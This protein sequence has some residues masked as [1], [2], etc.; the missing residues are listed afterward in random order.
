[1]E[2]IKKIKMSN[3]RRLL[4]DYHD[5]EPIKNKAENKAAI[6]VL[7]KF[8]KDTNGKKLNA[9]E[10]SFLDTLSDRIQDYEKKYS[11]LLESDSDGIESLK[12]LMDENGI[13]NTD[14]AMILRVN[15]STVSRIMTRKRPMTLFQINLLASYFCVEPGLFSEMKGI[16]VAVKRISNEFALV[17]VSS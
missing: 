13:N 3:W 10:K 8:T 2:T 11:D 9:D 6:E 1:M 4:L 14:L 7:I 5:L 16:S 12:F 17:P 15:R